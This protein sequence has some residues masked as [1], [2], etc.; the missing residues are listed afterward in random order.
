MKYQNQLEHA[1]GVL[2]ANIERVPDS[3]ATAFADKKVKVLSTA[4]ILRKHVAFGGKQ[5][6]V[7]SDTKKVDGV[8]DFDGN[9]LVDYRA[10]IINAIK[11]GYSSDAATGKEASLT[12][13][14]ALPVAFRNATLK[15]T[16]GG[17]IFNYP[18]SAL[19]NPHTGNSLAD[20]VIQLPQSFVIVPKQEFEMELIFPKGATAPANESYLEFTFYAEETRL[21]NS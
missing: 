9:S 3:L 1:L 2:K 20:D 14:S 17:I 6:L 11:L 8:S 15:I 10:L 16:Q 5:P 7:D 21:S 13:S 19:A 4:I 12:Y 18:L